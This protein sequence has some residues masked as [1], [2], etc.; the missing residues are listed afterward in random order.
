MKIIYSS[1]SYRNSV[2]RAVLS[3]VLG[4]VLVLWPGTALN[5]I[6]MLI[7]VLFLISGL[8]S[9]A[10]SF[11]VKENNSSGLRSFNG[12]GS[13]ILG[14]L[15]VAIPATFAQILMFVLGFILVVAGI[16]Q[17][18]LMSSARKLGYASPVFGYFFPGL[19]LLVGIII[20]FNP[21]ESATSIFILFGLTAIFYGVTDL[22]N[23]Y[24]INRLMKK[25]GRADQE[26]KMNGKDDVEDVDY[27]EV[28]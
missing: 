5:Y 15:L 20:L 4:L 11:K 9:F 26:K 8:I 2:L 7:G 23:Q 13:I 25:T 17:M 6:I 1:T 10:M 22:I 27:E 16:S 3:I 14:L 24:N 19:I 12:I 28:N 18:V 21:F